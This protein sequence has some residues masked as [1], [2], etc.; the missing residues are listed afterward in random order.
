MEREFIS[1]DYRFGFP[2]TIKHTSNDI[3]GDVYLKFSHKRV[4]FGSSG[5]VRT[6]R[7]PR[8]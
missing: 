8:H 1:Q 3:I 7:L 4:G 6:W 5:R 2:A